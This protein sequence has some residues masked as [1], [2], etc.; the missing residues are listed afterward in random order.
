[1]RQPKLVLEFETPQH[2]WWDDGAKRGGSFKPF[3]H[4]KG[5]IEWGCYELNYWFMADFG[6]SWE[7]AV[8]IAHRALKANTK[9]PNKI[10]T[11]W[12]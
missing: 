6:G 4:P 3:K 10:T 1:M 9:V 11:I 5:V 7:Q 12:E 2:G 8:K